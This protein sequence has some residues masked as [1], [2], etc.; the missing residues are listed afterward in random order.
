MPSGP[1]RRPSAASSSASGALTIVVGA[2]MCVAQRHLKRLLAF[3]TISHMGVLLIGIGAA[4]APR[5]RRGPRCT[6]WPTGPSRPRCSSAV[7]ILLNRYGSVDE[8]KL[9]GR[10]G[11]LRWVQALFVL[12]ALGLAGLPPFGTSLGKSLV[13][14]AGHELHLEWLPPLFLLGAALTGG[15]VLR[16]AGRVFWGWGR[17]E[18]D[19]SQSE[20]EA[21]ETQESYTRAP[22][23]MLLPVALLVAASL[24]VGLWPGL[25]PA[26]AVG[27][28]RFLDQP[29]YLSAVLDRATARIR[30]VPG[31]AG[32]VGHP[33]ESGRG[34]GRRRRRRLVAV[35][36]ARPV[37]RGQRARPPAAGPAP[38]P[39]QRRRSATTSPGPS[40]AP[41]CWAASAPTPCASPPCHPGA[42][43][44]R[45]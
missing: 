22:F 6:R 32:P 4:D 30:R 45:N 37:P 11:D 25:R 20:D 42:P 1:T 12:A 39:A 33:L 36:A 16:A 9:R 2:A 29:G 31:R 5:P 15:A 17:A 28:Q 14:E 10:A 21:P 44:A 35:R 27:A 23:V 41:P 7:G 38:R 13:E 40:S 8:D 34:A 24:A 3:S 19:P 18:Q 43:P 26:A